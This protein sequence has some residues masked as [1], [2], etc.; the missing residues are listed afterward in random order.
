PPQEGVTAKL[1]RTFWKLT[2]PAQRI[3][4]ALASGPMR[5]IEVARR[6]GMSKQLAFYHLRRMMASGALQMRRVE[7]LKLYFLPG[8]PADDAG[9]MS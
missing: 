9:G 1:A 4:K 8:E 3:G 5:L 2:S 7:G 6:A